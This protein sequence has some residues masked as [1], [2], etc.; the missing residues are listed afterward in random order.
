MD[1]RHDDEEGWPRSS[2]RRRHG[3][4]LTGAWFLN[5]CLVL[6][7]GCIVGTAG[8]SDIL[9]RALARGDRRVGSASSTTYIVLPGTQILHFLTLLYSFNCPDTT[10]Y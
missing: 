4:I 3:G 8:K 6:L 7:I 1:R 9:V 5:S 2:P 10:N